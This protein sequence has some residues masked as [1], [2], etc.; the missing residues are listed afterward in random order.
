MSGKVDVNIRNLLLLYHGCLGYLVLFQTETSKCERRFFA[1]Y[2]LRSKLRGEGFE[3]YC[4]IPG[5]SVW[6]DK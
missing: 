3:Q 4:A 2:C 6:S 1:C 5:F